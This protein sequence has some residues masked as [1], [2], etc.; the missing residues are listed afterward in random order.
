[1]AS[2]RAHISVSSV[3]V[4]VDA[5]PQQDLTRIMEEIRTQYEG[6]VEKNRRETET[7]YKEK[8][9]SRSNLHCVSSKALLSHCK[10]KSE[11]MILYIVLNYF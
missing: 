7:W 8:V 4:E 6:I 1:M 9:R 3:N 10:K 11:N 5:A 2:L